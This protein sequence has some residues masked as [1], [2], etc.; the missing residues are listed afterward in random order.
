MFA[1]YDKLVN[2]RVDIAKGHSCLFSHSYQCV[3]TQPIMKWKTIL[4]EKYTLHPAFTFI[5]SILP[6]SLQRSTILLILWM[7]RAQ[8]TYSDVFPFLFQS[9]LEKRYL[10]RYIAHVRQDWLTTTNILCI[11]C[12]SVDDFRWI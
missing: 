4:D 7:T 8:R 10:S 1:V 12:K 11:Y 5:H 2:D 3:D 6:S 9:Y